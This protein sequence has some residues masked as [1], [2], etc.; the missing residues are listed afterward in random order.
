MAQASYEA[1]DPDALE[2]IY[3]ERYYISDDVD[4]C[5]TDGG[6]LP[7]GSVTYR[8]FAD[9]KPDYLLETVFG[10][11]VN[12]IAHPL[13]ISTTTEFFNNEDRGDV[14]GGSFNLGQANDNTVALDS[15]LAFG[16]SVEDYYAVPKD[17]DT[18]GSVLGGM[19][20][21]G[22]SCIAADGLLSNS[23][24]TACEPLTVIDGMIPGLQIAFNSVGLSTN[25]TTAT[26]NSVHMFN[27][28]NSGDDCYLDNA[29]WAPLGGA[30][31]V[32]EENMILIGQFTTNGELSFKLNMRLRIPSELVCDSSICESFIDYS[33]EIFPEDT[34]GQPNYVNDRLIQIPSLIFNSSTASFNCSTTAVGV[35]EQNSESFSVFPNPVQDV[36]TVQM[37][38]NGL[39]NTL[40]MSIIDLQGRTVLSENKTQSNL[41]TDV[42]A[43]PAGVYILE[44]RS[45]LGVSSRR[46]LKE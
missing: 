17:L 22:G 45:S 30:G 33:A 15:Y 21:D 36:L 29:A 2:R 32:T 18:D 44:L 43:L 37:M 19:N 5:D 6:S 8:V 10:R 9:L 35:A 42:S 26:S 24:T 4:A 34:M 1:P 3:V 14:F 16:N 46:F 7:E 25:D 28:F 41:R 27:D 20:N 31:A 23:D 12:G 39:G 38:E 13:T 11:I 40:Q